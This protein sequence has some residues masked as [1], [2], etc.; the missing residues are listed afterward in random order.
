MCYAAYS[1]DGRWMEKGGIELVNCIKTIQEN[2]V[3]DESHIMLAFLLSRSIDVLCSIFARWT[4][5]GERWSW[6]ISKLHKN[7]PGKLCLG[8]IPYYV[9]ISF[10]HK[11]YAE[12]SQDGLWME[13]GSHELVKP[14][15][16]FWMEHYIWDQSHIMPAFLLSRS[17]DVLCSIFARWTE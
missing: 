2:Y 15:N 8:W 11:C 1:Q 10:V 5:N 3:W 14:L 17:I 12:Y 4:V 7:H 13:K 6:W 16:L 9:C